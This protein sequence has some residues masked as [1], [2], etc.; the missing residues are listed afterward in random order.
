VTVRGFIR[1]YK[2]LEILTNEQVEAIH[3]GALDVL[4]E[5]GVRVEHERALKLLADHGCEADFDEE[6][7]RIP[8][9]LVEDS[10]RRCPSSFVVRSRNSKSGVRIGRNSLYFENSI[11]MKIID[12]D[13]WEPR[14]AT[15]SEQHE[16]VRVLD[17]LD[18]LHLLTTYAPYADIEGVP[19]CVT[20]LESL[21]SR[22][23]NSSKCVAA[24]HFNG[25]EKFAV[26]M[27]KAVGTDLLGTI[28]A[29]PPLT[30]YEDTV[31]AAFRFAEAGF[32]VSIGSCTVMGGSGPVTIAGAAVISSAELMAGIVLTQL[33]KPGL[34]VLVC[35][36]VYP[37]DMHR[38]HLLFGASGAALHNVA[39]NQIW[40]SCKIPTCTWV[41]GVTSSKQIDFQC[42]YE[43]GMTALLCALSGSNLVSLHGAVYGE[44]AFHPVQAVLDDDIAGWVGRCIEGVQVTDETLAIDLIEEVGPIP[45]S[46]LNKEHTRKWWKT[47]QFV[48][49]AA[50]RESYPEWARMGKKTA[51][52]LAEE[53]MKEILATHEPIP[54]TSEQ[55]RSIEAILKE[56]R[57]NYMQ[58]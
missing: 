21:A 11:G 12:L 10:L 46:Y 13:T 55:E 22:I 35:D 44:L 7:V 4:R 40:R 34:A 3:Q 37:M 45:G 38:G 36:S 9:W 31:E 47:E 32:P 16:G 51:M 24:S 43:R 56:A 2:P 25:S 15:M 53:R 26:R 33:M 28:M 30:Y 42:A 23:R 49:E 29:S 27:A 52:A 48:P 41:A 50:D 17:A 57:E 8:S 58:C 19:P 20:M 39:F 54:L 6:R 14:P 18:N 1:K 5:T